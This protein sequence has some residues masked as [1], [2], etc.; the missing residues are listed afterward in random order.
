VTNHLSLVF[1]SPATEAGARAGTDPDHSRR[2]RGAYGGPLALAGVPPWIA[3]LQARSTPA[4]VRLTWEPVVGADIASY[5]VYRASDAGF[6]PLESMLIALVPSPSTAFL[7]AA[8]LAG[9]WYIVS[10]VDLRGH[11]GGFS[12]AAS[13][14]SPT[15]AAGG[16]V[17]LAL[18]PVRPNPARRDAWI[19]FE[20]PQARGAILEVFDARG[21]RV[22][23]FEA[24]R[25]AGRGRIHWDGRDDTGHLVAAGTYWLRL[26][27][28]SEHR[29]TKL[30]WIR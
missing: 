27:A 26:A 6:D 9:S 1:N 7:D 5:A 22:R 15:D 20:V 25:S 24:A 29:T 28:G 11:A 17:G 10:A 30:T 4:G 3:G 19:E 8:P 12:P 16:P 23:R 13:A 14:T 2:D 18:H 21:A